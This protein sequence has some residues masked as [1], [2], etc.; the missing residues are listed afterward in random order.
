MRRKKIN[1]NGMTF[2][3]HGSEKDPFIHCNLISGVIKHVE[4]K[5]QYGIYEKSQQI[6]IHFV[7]EE[8]MNERNQAE[9]KK[10]FS[11]DAV[12]IYELEIEI[13]KIS[14]QIGNLEKEIKNIESKIKD[15]EIQLTAS[16]TECIIVRLRGQCK[17]LDL[18]KSKHQKCLEVFRKKREDLSKE[19]IMLLK[20]CE[21]SDDN[22]VD[23][24]KINDIVQEK[25]DRIGLYLHKG[26]FCKERPEIWVCYDRIY[27]DCFLNGYLFREKC[28]K[29]VAAITLM[30]VLHELGHAIMDGSH[31]VLP[32]EL[33]RWVEEPLANYIALKYMSCCCCWPFDYHMEA[34]NFVEKQKPPYNMGLIL[35]A[36]SSYTAEEMFNPVLWSNKKSQQKAKTYALENW[37]NYLSYLCSC[38]N[39]RSEANELYLKAMFYEIVRD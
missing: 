34:I 8:E 20:T 21:E 11:K 32:H 36:K 39:P 2:V 24:Q 3:D 1:V 15:I 19:Y 29:E 10:I 38:S 16:N 26:V 13:D 30:V 33:Y 31:E 7:K 23:H 37:K 12:R 25:T 5:C 22:L 6:V 4:S 18:L 9:T 27:K 14:S 28:E 35:H 17:E